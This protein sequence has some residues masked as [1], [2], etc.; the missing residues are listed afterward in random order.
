MKGLHMQAFSL[1]QS[2]FAHNIHSLTVNYKIGCRIRIVILVVD[3]DYPYPPQNILHM[4][5]QAAN[6]C[7]IPEAAGYLPFP[8][9]QPHGSEVRCSPFL[10]AGIPPGGWLCRIC[11]FGSPAHSATAFMGYFVLHFGHT[12]L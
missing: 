5:L 1:L 9:R 2:Q 10:P 7:C 8:P 4:S 12:F 3:E 6:A 11:T